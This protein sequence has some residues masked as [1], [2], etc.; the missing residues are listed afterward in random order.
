MSQGDGFE[1]R[2]TTRAAALAAAGLVFALGCA[3][4]ATGPSTPVIEATLTASA[5]A[6]T[7]PVASAATSSAGPVAVAKRVETVQDIQLT[8]ELPNDAWRRHPGLGPT[9]P[10]VTQLGFE[11]DDVLDDDGHAVRPYCGVTTEPAPD[12][13]DIVLYS[14]GWRMKA[15]FK[16]DSV[17]THEDGT[18]Q[19][20]SAIGY[21]G[22]TEYGG[23]EHSLFVVHGL[24]GERGYVFICD[25]TTSVLAKVE[26]EI[27]SILRS[28]KHRE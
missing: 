21:R 17:F 6:S 1:R 9:P 11:R 26:G 10:G 19:V 23:D 24:F 12:Q 7:A 18:V 5:Q 4:A 27:A 28:M 2:S 25:T 20:K 8:F 13:K 16:V 14:M 15:P 22:R 3:E